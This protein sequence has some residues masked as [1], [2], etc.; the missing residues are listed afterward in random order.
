[1]SNKL[2]VTLD[3][4]IVGCA[5]SGTTGLAERLDH[6]PLV[7]MSDVKE[8]NYFVHGFEQ[9]TATRN[10]NGSI[11]LT[12]GK[13]ELH[14]DRLERFEA[15]F[16][17]ASH[18][19]KLGEASP[20]YLLNPAVPD[21]LLAHNPDI[22]IVLVL[23]NPTDVAFSNF[24]HHV[25]DRMESV[26]VNNM[27]V[28]LDETRYDD[29]ELHVFA[30]HLLIPEYSTHLP[31]WVE[32]F[33]PDRLH[34]EI[35]EEFRA[36]PEATFA[37]VAE[38][39][40]LP[41]VTLDMATAQVNQ[42]RIPRFASLHSLVLND[43]VMKRLLRTLVPTKQRRR[44]R[45]A[46]ERLNAG[47]RPILTEAVRAKLDVRYAKDRT[48]VSSLLGRTLDAWEERLDVGSAGRES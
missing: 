29:P 35:Y 37:R 21:R 15:L 43:S 17:G 10:A 4:A 14:V 38:F 1:M 13:P 30:R 22:R 48:Y 11:A 5:K 25:R 3:F 47:K 34:I 6:H 28:L 2:P 36:F 45:L 44:L 23:R 19:Q 32:R 24:V 12:H 8:T 33:G 27:E 16:R 18:E 40:D 41:E 20:L 31:R 26:D 39:L 46:V 42:S 9:A 7:Y